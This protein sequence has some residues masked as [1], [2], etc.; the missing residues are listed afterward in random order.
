MRQITQVKRVTDLVGILRNQAETAMYAGCFDSSKAVEVA[1][2][3]ILNATRGLSLQNVNAFKANFECIDLADRE[4]RVAVQVT[5]NASSL[6]IKNT[7]LQFNKLNLIGTYSRLIIVGFCKAQ[8]PKCLPDHVEVLG[9]KALL[10]PL[11]T[12]DVEA[13]APLITRLENS[14]DFSLF[15]PGSDADCLRSIFGMLNRDALRHPMS[16]EGP[17]SEMRAALVEMKSFIA[18]GHAPNKENRSKPLSSFVEP[19]YSALQNIELIL[20][21]LVAELNRSRRG[22]HYYLDEQQKEDFDRSKAQ[23]A[24]ALNDICEKMQLDERVTMDWG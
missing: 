5:A 13:L 9:P 4:A 11:G 21:Q 19:C 2:T 7:I 14:I 24:N 18:T 8:K 15:A 1:V 3:H 6:K 23:V 17:F 10:S 22:E 12:Y 20:G 16:S